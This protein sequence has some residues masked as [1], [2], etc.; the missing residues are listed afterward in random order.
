MTTIIVS[1]ASKTFSHIEKGYTE[2]TTYTM[3]RRATKI[4]QLQQELRTLK[5]QYKKFTEEEKQALADLQ[6]ILRKRL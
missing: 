5:N 2:P 4:H 3:N 1:Y 6:N